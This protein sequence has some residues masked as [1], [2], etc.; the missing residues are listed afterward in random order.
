MRA[1]EAGAAAGSVGP[2]VADGWLPPALWEQR[3]EPPRW[4]RATWKDLLFGILGLGLL[5]KPL[6]LSLQLFTASEPGLGT[7]TFFNPA[8]SVSLGIGNQTCPTRCYVLDSL[9]QGNAIHPCPSPRSSA[10]AIEGNPSVCS[11][12]SCC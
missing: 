10:A 6:H 1:G 2:V 3:W 4:H 12:P 8:P 5:R 9:G 11:S 7:G